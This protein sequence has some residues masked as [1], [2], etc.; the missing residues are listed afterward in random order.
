MRIV[1]LIASATEIACALGR[2]EALV[3]RS[4]ECDFPADVLSLP[5]LTAP[6]FDTGLSSR[7]IDDAVKARAGHGLSVY[8]IDRDK[9][10]TLAPDVILTQD[11]CEVCAASLREVEAAVC[12]WVGRS[13]RI[14][15][16]KPN[17]LADIW[18][19][20]TRVGEAIDRADAAALLI[21]ALKRRI[22]DARVAAPARVVCVEWIEPL[23]TAG[24]WIPELVRL[25]GAEPLL[26]SAGGPSPYV[27]LEEIGAADP[28]VIVVAPCGFDVA[29]SVAEMP[30]LA[31]QQAWRSLRAVR[32]RRVAIADGNKFFN[33]PSPSVADT[34]EILADILTHFQTQ[35]RPRFGADVWKVQ[36]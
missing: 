28:D 36:A 16:L 32:E 34:V 27:S 33:R 1:S 31:G 2:R 19:D 24:H 10:R 23:M 13:V 29:R 30:T 26:A 7:A 25:A 4:H 5:A 9:L 3:G 8:Q 14:I 18:D 21:A 12:E 6:T 17:S 22:G 15:S 11:Q 20:I 35:E